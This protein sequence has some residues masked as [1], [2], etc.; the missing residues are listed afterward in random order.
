MNRENFPAGRRPSQYAFIDL[1]D[2]TSSRRMNIDG[3]VTPV[4]FSHTVPQDSRLVIGALNFIMVAPTISPEDFGNVS[5]LTNGVELVV[6][7]ESMV[8]ELDFGSIVCN[9]DFL[10]LVGRNYRL[11]RAMG[12]QVDVFVGT[13]RLKDLG[14]SSGERVMATVNDDLS[15]LTVFRIMMNGYVLH[16]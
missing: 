1:V 4:I 3:S 7:N 8:N 9:A 10:P 15:S 11:D 16:L 6:K 13:I 14:L 12:A 5:E 2:G